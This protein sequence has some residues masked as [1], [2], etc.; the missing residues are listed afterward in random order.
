[1]IEAQSENLTIDGS[2]VEDDKSALQ[3]AYQN[4]I[5]KIKAQIG[6]AL[7][8]QLNSWQPS[9]SV[10]ASYPFLADKTTLVTNYLYCLDILDEGKGEFS[11]AINKKSLEEK[12]L[13]LNLHKL[14]EYG[15]QDIPPLPHIRPVL[16]G[17]K[18][19]INKALKE[20]YK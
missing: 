10:I 2:I 20:V 12:H 1:M 3:K 5:E 8:S 4:L 7:Q 16:S 11:L 15:N 13:P 17:I 9:P 6:K 14:L 19:E 18:E